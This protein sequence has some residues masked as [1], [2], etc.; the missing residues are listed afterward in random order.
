MISI[1]G[2][3]V[4]FGNKPLFVDA[5]FVINDRDFNHGMVKYCFQAQYLSIKRR[6]LSA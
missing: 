6:Y 3:R 5:S 2:L 4:E 1:E